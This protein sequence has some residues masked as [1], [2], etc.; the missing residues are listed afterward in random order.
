[1]IATQLL[2]GLKATSYMKLGQDKWHLLAS[3]YKHENI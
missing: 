2:N 3:G 1:M